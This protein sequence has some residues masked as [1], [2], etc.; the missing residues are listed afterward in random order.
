VQLSKQNERINTLQINAEQ[1]QNKREETKN[2][3]LEVMI[4]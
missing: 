1:A 2:S 4:E 3:A